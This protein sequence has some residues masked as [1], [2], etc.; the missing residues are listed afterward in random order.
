MEE[1]PFKGWKFEYIRMCWLMF[2]G[3]YLIFI[4]IYFYSRLGHVS[5]IFF[6]LGIISV[7]LGVMSKISF[8]N[9][10]KKYLSDKEDNPNP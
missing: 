3:L 10:Y 6:P 1:K 5:L 7:I 2:I 9:K 4:G 8:R